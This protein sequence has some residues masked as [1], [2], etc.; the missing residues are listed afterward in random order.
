LVQLAA[1]LSFA[2]AKNNDRVGLLLFSDRVEH[3]VP[4]KKGR[5]HVHRILRDLLYFKPQ[6]RRTNVKLALETLNGVLRKR[7]TIFVLSDFLAPEF[8]RALRLVG[9]RHDVVAVVI[10]DQAE[11]KF[12]RVGL[13]DL[14]DAE[15]GEM[16]TV[17][18]SSTEFRV[19]Y[20]K[21]YRQM[22]M[23]RDQQLTK[24]QVDQVR[25][26]TS[27]SFVDPLVKFFSSRHKK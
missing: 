13:I 16:V 21:H 10:E 4:P 15:T 3:F 24:S 1:V 23:V 22:I 27:H 20:E 18:T 8:D 26:D 2:A 19:D 5:G 14:Q 11:K 12:P 17:D 25:V 7:A 6:G 9:R